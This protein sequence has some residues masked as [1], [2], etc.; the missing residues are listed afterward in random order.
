[1]LDEDGLPQPGD[2]IKEGDPWYSYYDEAT[3]KHV[4]IT[5]KYKEEAIIDD[6]IVC[7]FD[8]KD[9]VLNAFQRV[10]L[11]YRLV[12]KPARGDKFSSRHGQKGVMSVLFPQIDMPFTSEGLT[13][14]VIINPNAF[15][16]RMTIGTPVNPRLLPFTPGPVC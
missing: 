14:D 10:V 15:P 11:K 4:V 12:R 6:V 16:S 1:M 9:H 2:R 5:Y 13:P 7:G 8:V 3:G